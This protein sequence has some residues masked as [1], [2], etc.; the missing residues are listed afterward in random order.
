[1]DKHRLMMLNSSKERGDSYFIKGNY[2]AVFRK[3]GE[4]VLVELFDFNKMVRYV[5]FE[6]EIKGEVWELETSGEK[7]E[8]VVDKC[9]NEC[10]GVKSYD[11]EVD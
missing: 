4:Y 8:Y 6:G 7:L 2:L 9:V 1:V 3:D 11:I 10:C 5:L